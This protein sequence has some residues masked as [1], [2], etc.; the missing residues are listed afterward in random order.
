MHEGATAKA[1]AELKKMVAIDEA[2]KDFAAMSGTY[3]QMGNILLE[4]GRVDAAKAKFDAQVAAMDKAEVAAPVK[5]ATRRQHIF[6][7]ARI[8]LARN[9][10]DTAKAK[11]A[12]YIA[13]AEVKKIPF[14]VRQGHELAGRFALAQKNYTVAAGEL[15]QANNQDPRVLFLLATAL[16]AKG[17]AAAAKKIAAQAADWNA[18]SN[19]Y[20]YVRGKARAIATTQKN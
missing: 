10:L 14:E 6:D 5:E 4:A 1:L 13:A 2:N 8:A 12:A 9:D 19:T 15:Q 11:T 17:D 3:N 18:L 7:E 16:Q 20:G